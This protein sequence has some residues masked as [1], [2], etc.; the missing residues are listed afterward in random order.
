[1]ASGSAALTSSNAISRRLDQ[2]FRDLT[3]YAAG[4]DSENETTGTDAARKR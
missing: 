3:G 4:T 2:A 1:M